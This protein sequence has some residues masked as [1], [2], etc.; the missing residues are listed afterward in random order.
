MAGIV[1]VF[2]TNDVEGGI[3]LRHQILL[4]YVCGYK[5]SQSLIFHLNGL[6]IYQHVT[7]SST[8]LFSLSYLFGIIDLVD[9]TAGMSGS[10]RFRHVCCGKNN[11]NIYMQ[12]KCSQNQ[13]TQASEVNHDQMSLIEPFEISFEALAY[14][15]R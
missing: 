13:R 3:D 1:R 5:L 8:K 4:F 9:R 15:R 7:Q 10:K 11:E 12:T 6:G 14:S 2:L